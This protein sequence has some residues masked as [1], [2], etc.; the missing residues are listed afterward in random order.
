MAGIGKGTIYKGTREGH[1]AVEFG[2]KAPQSHDV[3][4]AIV[5]FA[6]LGC[7]AAPTRPLFSYSQHIV[8]EYVN[9]GAKLRKFA[10]KKN[11]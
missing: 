10:K 2:K 3:D 5:H 8:L 4:A 7:F 1:A 9:S 6:G 11:D